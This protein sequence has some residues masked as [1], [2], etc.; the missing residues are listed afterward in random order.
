MKTDP[1]GS[2]PNSSGSSE[3]INRS[4]QKGLDHPEGGC[5]T[6]HPHPSQL[7]LTELGSREIPL[8]TSGLL[9][10]GMR[11]LSSL[12]GEVHLS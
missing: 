12:C 10:G 1:E 7:S 9:Q 5:Y 11:R 3:A 2:N 4:G 8:G 6:S